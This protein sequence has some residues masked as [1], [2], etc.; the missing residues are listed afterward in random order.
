MIYTYNNQLYVHNHDIR[1][2]SKKSGVYSCLVRAFLF[3]PC[4]HRLIL[5]CPVLRPLFI[6]CSYSGIVQRTI[7]GVVIIRYYTAFFHCPACIR[8][9]CKIIALIRFYNKMRLIDEIWLLLGFFYICGILNKRQFIWLL[10]SFNVRRCPAWYNFLLCI[11]NAWHGFRRYASGVYPVHVRQ[12]VRMYS[13]IMFFF[14]FKK[15]YRKRFF[16]FC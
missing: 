6:P 16:V 5:F 4:M 7:S 8:L 14:Y 2:Y 10:Q 3:I 11:L 13:G 12:Y 15:R 1:T 9:L